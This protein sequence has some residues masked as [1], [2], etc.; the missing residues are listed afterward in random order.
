M[1]FMPRMDLTLK[2]S[3]ILRNG[4]CRYTDRTKCVH[5]YHSQ[6]TPRQKVNSGYLWASAQLASFLE[7]ARE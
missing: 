2:S 5:Y 7:Y 3:F 4:A 6:M 1:N